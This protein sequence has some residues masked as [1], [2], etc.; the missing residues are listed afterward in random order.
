M[1]SRVLLRAIGAGLVIVGL[2]S[3][4]VAGTTVAAPPHAKVYNIISPT[5]TWAMTGASRWSTRP[6]YWP[7]KAPMRAA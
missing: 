5:T 4:S 2:V 3:S 1:R 7:S 6:K